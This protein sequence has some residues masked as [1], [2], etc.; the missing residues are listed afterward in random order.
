MVRD[1]FANLDPAKQARLFEAAAD[2]FSDKGYEGASLNRIIDQAGMSKGSLYYYFEDKSDLYAAVVEKATVR[3]LSMV[4]GFRIEDLSAETFWPSFEGMIRRS[5]DLIGSNEWFVRLARSFFRLRERGSPRSTRR[6]F[7]WMAH[8]TS[9]ALTRGREIGV[10]RTD[11]PLPYLVEMCLAVG[12]VGDR[13]LFTH[14]SEL[15]A[16]EREGL[17]MAE[18]DLFHRLLDPGSR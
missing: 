9:A 6:I 17:V 16:A 8:W 18:L 13:W 5:V 10:V 15:S 12:E 7:D 1:R 11:L 3:I 14:W 4:G 2:E